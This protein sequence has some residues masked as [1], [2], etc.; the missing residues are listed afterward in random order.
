[1]TIYDIKSRVQETESKFFDRS[2]LKFFGQTMRMFR[3]AKMPD[4]RYRISAPFGPGQ[5]R[6]E[7]VRFF[8][9]TTNRLETK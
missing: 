3:V 9:P 1:M 6:G 8:D 5:P 2:T 7:T 4:G